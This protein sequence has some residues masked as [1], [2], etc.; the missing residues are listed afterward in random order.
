[1]SEVLNTNNTNKAVLHVYDAQ[2]IEALEGLEAVRKRPGMYIGDT[3]DGSGLHHMI[4]EIVDNS[5]DEAQAGFCDRVE[6]TLN[7]DYSVTVSDNGR[8]IPVDVNLKTNR[9]AIELVF[10]ELHA[11]GKF[12]QNAYKTSGGLHGVGASVVNALCDS[13]TVTVYRNNKEYR[14]GFTNGGELTE[15][16]HIVEENK[17]KTGTVVN[18]LPSKAIFRDI[19]LD[20]SKIEARLRQLAFLNSGIKIVFYDKRTRGVPPV[21]MFYD[22]GLAEFVKFI[23]KTKDTVMAKPVTAKGV[24]LVDQG[25]KE[26]EVSADVSFQWNTGYTEHVLC[27]TNNIPQRDGGTHLSGFRAALTRCIGDYASNNLSDKEKIA[28]NP[29]DMREGLSAVISVKVPDPK[30]SSQTK[31]KLVSS[32]VQ[33]AVQSIVMDSLKVW[34]DE[35]PKEAK[36]IIRKAAEA[37][38]AR[39]AARKARENVRKSA[40]QETANLAGKLADCSEKDPALTEIFIV[41]GDSA[42]GSAKQG[43][44]RKFQAILPLRGKVL[45]VERTRVDKILGNDQIGTLL[46]ALGLPTME[47]DINKL[48]YH[49]IIIMTDADVD[50]SHIRTLLITFFKRRLPEIIENGF[51]YIAQPPLF[52]VEKSKGKGEKT[53][54]LNEEKLSQYMFKNGTKDG[55]LILE[56]G[57]IVDGEELYKLGLD[58]KISMGYIDKVN[59]ETFNLLPFTLCLAVTG[60]WHPDVF[61]NK[62]NMLAT[63]EYVN[64]LMPYYMPKTRWSGE[65]KD[66]KI[67]FNWRKTGVDHKIVLDSSISENK[68]VLIL[69]KYL[70][71]FQKFYTTKTK[72]VNSNREYEIRSPFDLSNILYKFG[73]DGLDVKRYKGLGEMNPEQLELTTLMPSNRS[74]LQI[75]VKDEEETDNL[76]SVLM[77]DEPQLRKDFLSSNYSVEDLDI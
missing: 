13:M 44:N 14:I 3:D 5:M 21:E 67:H 74:L 51:L 72:F 48:R 6:I 50:G 10:M 53:Y 56:N 64:S 15:P 28:L 12:N 60:A 54:L 25:G 33:S 58:S 2:D 47:F 63:M 22:G 41:E 43:R 75:K 38:A 69:L 77:G 31:D 27:F 68:N 16:L 66:G 57:D 35:N 9:P 52:S 59:S 7:D 34:L 24:K 32:E 46:T 40:G 61:E 39:E 29:D 70:N 42:G 45:N 30:F 23:D 11:G 62:E 36:I 19:T 20:S 17:R 55:Q 1:M 71:D 18:F 4:Q 49:K 73:S 65:V 37:A 76:L 8:G 26:I